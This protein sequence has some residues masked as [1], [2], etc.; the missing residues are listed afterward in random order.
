MYYVY[1]YDESA[2]KLFDYKTNVLPHIGDA[3]SNTSEHVCQGNYVVAK[4]IL[5]TATDC[6]NVLSIW[7]SKTCDAII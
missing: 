7:V 1:V 4:R 5:H 6:T 2:T 3:Y